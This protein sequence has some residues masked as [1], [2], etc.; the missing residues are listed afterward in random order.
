[1]NIIDGK[2]LAAN[3][4]AEIAAGVKALKEEKGITPGL[5]VILVG[6]NPASV[7]YVTA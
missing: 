6:N 7:S 4:R 1:M 2:Q 3:L 5:A